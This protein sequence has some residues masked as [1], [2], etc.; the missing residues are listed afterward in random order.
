MVASE[1]AVPVLVALERDPRAGPGWWTRRTEGVPTI[2]AET[3]E[4]KES[5]VSGDGGWEVGIKM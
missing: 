5:R 2:P 1:G 4:E 3:E